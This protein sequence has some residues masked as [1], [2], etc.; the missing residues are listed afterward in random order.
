MGMMNAK[1]YAKLKPGTRVKPKTETGPGLTKQE[2]AHETNINNIMARY[3]ATG[4]LPSAIVAQQAT[5]ADVSKLGSFA[6]V[7]NRV[8]AAEEA[9]A[10]MPAS[11]RTRFDND[12]AKLVAFIQDGKNRPEAEALGLVPKKEPKAPKKDPQKGPDAGE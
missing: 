2:F 8:H 12:P 1:E 10:A 6:D 11:I 9:F 4:Q 7:M 5:F 3:I